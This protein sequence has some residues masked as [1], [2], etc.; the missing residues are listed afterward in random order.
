MEGLV[1]LDAV[2]DNQQLVLLAAAHVD[3]GRDVSAGRTG[4]AFDGSVE[5]VGR[6]RHFADFLPVEELPA[7]WLLVEKSKVARGDDDLVEKNG[8][9]DQLEANAR[10]PSLG[11]HHVVELL[12]QKGR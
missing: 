9:R 6:V 3:F 4:Q 7:L 8:H 10:R 11:D 12:G 5:I 2:E 1:E